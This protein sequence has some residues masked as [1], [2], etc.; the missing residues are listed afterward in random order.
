[1]NSTKRRIL[2]TAKELLNAQGLAAVSQRTIAEA[3]Q[4]SPGNLTYHFKK[5]SDIIEA[6][7]F[8]LVACID[9]AIAGLTIGEELLLGLYGLTQ[10]MMEYFFDYRFIMLDFIQIMREYPTIRAHYTELLKLREIQLSHFFEVLIATGL[11][12]PPSLEKEYENL[13]RRQVILG[14]FWLASAEIKEEKLTL[15]QVDEYL[16][17]MRQMI[18]PYLTRKGKTQFQKI[19]AAQ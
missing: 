8:E 17:M 3:L 16:V 7:Y 12:R 11:M 2:D 14:D 18:Y 6:L 4:I 15:Q 1:M 13:I 10:K 5:K 9:Q 19:I